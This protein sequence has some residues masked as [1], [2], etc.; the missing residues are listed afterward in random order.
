MSL[1]QERQE[2]LKA[3][4]EV[5]R[6]SPASRPQKRGSAAGD[7]KEANVEVRPTKRRKTASPVNGAGREEQ[8]ESSEL[9]ELHDDE[10]SGKAMGS[11]KKTARP[12]KNKE[13]NSRPAKPVGGKNGVSSKDEKALTNQPRPR[14][15]PKK[16]ESEDD[17]EEDEVAKPDTKMDEPEH[18]ADAIDSGSELSSLI[19]EDEAPKKRRKSKDSS[20]SKPKSKPNSE[21]AGKSK[22]KP[23]ETSQDDAEIAEIKR[24]QGWL[25]KCGI[26][27][28]WGKELKPYETSREKIKH[29]RD[30]LAEIGM[31]G[32]YS[33]E[34]AAQIREAR[35]LAADIEAVTEGNERWGKD[36]S[37]AESDG[38]QAR[39]ARRSLV[40]G[41]QT[42]DF[43][44]SDG[45]ETD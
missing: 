24:L 29:L 30:L 44:S 4:A 42:F 39:P 35:E 2:A 27:K 19:D 21:S 11:K 33:Q 26:R 14:A 36:Q 45:E 31:T 5:G 9:S 6:T 25:A 3:S 38:S 8:S 28:L 32:R 1:F 43:L 12:T 10:S 16:I 7:K 40:R 20:K 17:D 34:K 41:A 37:G 15:K 18:T 13:V 23:K 22:P